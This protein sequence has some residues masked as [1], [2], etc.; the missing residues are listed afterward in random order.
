MPTIAFESNVLTI[1]TG[2]VWLILFAWLISIVLTVYGLA[3]QKRLSPT[4]HLRMTA[5]DAPLVSVLVPAR[6]EQN[7][8]LADC[9]R[10]ILA[11][12]YG[13]F[14]VIAVTLKSREEE[15]LN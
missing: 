1:L 4:N 15:F 3:R 9:I 6:N 10:S 2:V 8:V 5:S 13:R 11:Q 14:E 7:R 12:D